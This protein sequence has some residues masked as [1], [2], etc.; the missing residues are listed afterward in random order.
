MEAFPP[1]E[2]NY[3]G[4]SLHGKSALAVESYTILPT[5][6]YDYDD[7]DDL[8]EHNCYGQSK[9]TYQLYLTVHEFNVRDILG[10]R[11]HI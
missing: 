8:S 1:L 10:E 11:Q 5:S 6:Y 4:K 2:R 9:S 7:Y 3:G